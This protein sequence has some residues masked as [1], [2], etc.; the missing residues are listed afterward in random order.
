MRG[1]LGDLFDLA[2]IEFEVL[3]C[4]ALFLAQVRF[5]LY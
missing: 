3:R 2:D 4:P 5:E 1:G